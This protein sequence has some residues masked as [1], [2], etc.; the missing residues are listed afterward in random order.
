MIDTVFRLDGKIVLVTGA[1]SGIG[2]ATAQICAS[3]G[4]KLIITGRDKNRLQESL[5]SLEGKGHRSVVFDFEN[6]E[7]E[8]ITS[9]IN[10]KLDGIVHSAG[11][12]EYIPFAFTN[13]SK[14]DRIMRVN[15]IVPFTLTQILVKEKKIQKAA[16]IVFVSSISGVSTISNGLSAYSSSKG[17]LSAAVRVLALEL[18]SRRIRVNA[19][20]PGMVK[21]EMTVSVESITQESLAEDEKANYPLGYGEPSDIANSICFLLSNA[22]KWITGTNLIIDGGASI[23]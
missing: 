3:L 16:S 1:S 12:L 14:L 8:D 6:G 11:L 20:C 5:M 9:N 17:A 23:H 2:R 15:F 13:S 19:I 18:A 10:E 22:S 21:S 7:F 4:A